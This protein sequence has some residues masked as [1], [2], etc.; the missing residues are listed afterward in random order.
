MAVKW[1]ILQIEQERLM[2]LWLNKEELN[3]R[4]QREW[5]K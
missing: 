2:E 3:G 5:K 1:E 4:A